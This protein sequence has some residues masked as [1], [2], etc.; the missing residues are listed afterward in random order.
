MSNLMPASHTG[1]FKVRCIVDYTVL[2]FGGEYYALP[3]H[4]GSFAWIVPEGSGQGWWFTDKEVE[5]VED[6]IKK[7]TP[8][9]S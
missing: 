2:A 3:S 5:V 9:I 8:Y 6:D 4:D 7:I 1:T